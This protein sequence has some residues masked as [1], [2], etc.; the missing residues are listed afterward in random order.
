MAGGRSKN[1]QRLR[2][3]SSERI[4]PE[5]VFKTLS[6]FQFDDEY[7]GLADQAIVLISV[8]LLEQMLERA[9]AVHFIELN[10]VQRQKIFDGDYEHEGILG[11]IYSRTLIAHALGVVSQNIVLDLNSIR[12]IRNVFAHS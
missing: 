1:V 3:L 2:H 12:Y 7:K 10:D 9:I 6:D 8:A 4:A 11:D 5:E